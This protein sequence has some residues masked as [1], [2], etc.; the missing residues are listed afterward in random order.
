MSWRDLRH[1][2]PSNARFDH[3][4][5]P[6][7]A[8]TRGILYAAADP[9]TCI[10]EVF[11]ATRVIERNAKAPWFVAFDLARGV[12]LLDLTGR[13]PTL[14]GASMAISSGQR[15]RAR[16]WSAA[17]HAAYP[18]V[19]G[20]LYGSSMHANLPSVALYERA[21]TAL[22]SAPAF[23]RALSDPALLLRLNAAATRIGYRLV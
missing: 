12:R 21:R 20:L 10:A 15:P 1:F 3:H 5:P 16:R 14:A 13:W 2:G 7:R 22:P 19:E 11:Q 4:V 23:H 8:Q 9:V 18:D 17:I 6:P